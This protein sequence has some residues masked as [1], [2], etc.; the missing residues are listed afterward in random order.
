VWVVDRSFGILGA[1]GRQSGGMCVCCRL[2]GLLV[3]QRMVS[4]IEVHFS[5]TSLDFCQ[6]LIFAWY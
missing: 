1:V 6:G 5:C 2:L 3:L 4:S